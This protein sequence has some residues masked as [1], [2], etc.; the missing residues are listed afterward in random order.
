MPG[1]RVDLFASN[2]LRRAEL[3][4][5]PGPVGVEF[6][7]PM[8]GEGSG[9]QQG[10]GGDQGQRPE[11]IPQADGDGASADGENQGLESAAD[12]DQRFVQRDTHDVASERT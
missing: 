10:N 2:G 7:P 8:K 9:Q 5:N 11:P 12:D 1:L 4:A 3:V 6:D